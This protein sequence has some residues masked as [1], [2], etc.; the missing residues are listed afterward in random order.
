MQARIFVRKFAFVLSPYIVC[1][2]PLLVNCKQYSTVYSVQVVLI[3]DNCTLLKHKV[4]I[5]TDWLETGKTSVKH[6]LKFMEN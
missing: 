6:K 1:C 4:S 5:S 3:P 2:V